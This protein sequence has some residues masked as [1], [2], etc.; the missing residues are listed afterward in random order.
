MAR[1]LSVYGDCTGWKVGLRHASMRGTWLCGALAKRCVNRTNRAGRLARQRGERERFRQ[2]IDAYFRT[3]K[4]RQ[5][6]HLS[7]NS[8]AIMNAIG[9][10]R[11]TASLLSVVVAMS[12]LAQPASE[13]W[14]GDAKRYQSPVSRRTVYRLTWMIIEKPPMVRSWSL[15]GNTIGWPLENPIPSWRPR[16]MPVPKCKRSAPPPIEMSRVSL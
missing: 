4:F 16:A 7:R 15:I 8:N 3:S 9:R 12:A 1:S 14:A 11:R 5:V 6:R 13:A 10:R 2:R